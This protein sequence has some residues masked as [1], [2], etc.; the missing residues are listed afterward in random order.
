LIFHHAS[1]REHGARSDVAS[2]PD[3]NAADVEPV[4]LDVEVAELRVEADGAVV[5]DG[6]QVRRLQQVGVQKDI[7]AQVRV[8][9]V[10]YV[11]LC[12]M[13]DL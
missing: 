1:A 5:S 7:L 12:V 11:P 4:A 6:D 8:R 2:A 9:A 13:C 10:C 3:D